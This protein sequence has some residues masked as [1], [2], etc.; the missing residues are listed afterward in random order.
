MSNSLNPGNTSFV[1][2]RAPEPSRS[3]IS[4]GVEAALSERFNIVR[5]LIDSDAHTL[6]L[7]EDLAHPGGIG[8][9]PCGLVRLRV[10]AESLASN[11]RQVE[12]FHLEA[13]AAARLSHRNI[14]KAAPAEEKNGIH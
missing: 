14:L 7:A 6:Y 3:D 4:A 1:A 10:L 13:N 12:L 8:Q 9:E 11:R 2:A 5:K